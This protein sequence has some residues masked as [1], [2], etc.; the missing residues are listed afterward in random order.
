MAEL[1]DLLDKKSNEDEDAPTEAKAEVVEEKE[2]EATEA[3]VPT[4]T[5]I[6]PVERDAENSHL[7]LATAGIGELGGDIDGGDLILPKIIQVH[8]VGD[9]AQEYEPGSAILG[10]GGDTFQFV[11]LPD[12]KD[13]RR[14]Y[15][16]SFEFIPLKM[17]KVWREY[18]DYNDKNMK[19]EIP[20]E[21]ASAREMIDAGC[22]ESYEPRPKGRGHC[23]PALSTMVA[24]VCKTDDVPEELVPFFCDEF[25]EDSYCL[26]MWRLQKSAYS[27]AGKVLITDAQRALRRTGILSARYTAKFENQKRGDNFVWCPVVSLNRARNPKDVQEFLTSL[28]SG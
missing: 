26:A 22:K 15:S 25:K 3:E 19:D 20:R 21:F 13:A 24:V 27:S 6:E 8:N 1:K 14:K 18:F 7:V 16:N 2:E 9:L 10:A 11:D 17:Q 28:V 5:E 23:R 4:S 12:D